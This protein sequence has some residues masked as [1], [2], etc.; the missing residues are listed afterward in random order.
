MSENIQFDFL[1]DNHFSE[2]KDGELQRERFSLALEAEPYIGKYYS[3]DWVRR[4]ILRQTDQDILEQDE[5]IEK[6]IDEG[7]IQ[8]PKELEMAVDGFNGMAPGVGE[9]AGPGGDLGTPIM[10][11]NLEGSKDAGRTKLPKGGEI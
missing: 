7:I 9:A 11:P 10:E 4:Q 1:Y 2:L 6:E 8:D 3:Q 5:L